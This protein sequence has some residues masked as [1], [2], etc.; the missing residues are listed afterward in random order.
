MLEDLQ[1]SVDEAGDQP[2]YRRLADAIAERIA[3]GQLAVGDR[4]PPQREIASALGINVTTVTRAFSTLQQR[5]LVEARPGRG[6][7]VVGP[8]GSAGGFKSAPSDESG[9]I[10]LSVNRPATSAYLDALA[11]LLPRLVKDRRYSALQD[12]HP[13]EGPL[14]ARAAI[15]EWLA[16][17]AGG[18]D[19]GRV[20]LTE[21]AQHGLACVLAAVAER[22][23]V[24]LADSV[25][26]QGINAL[27][28][29]RGLDL[30]GVAMDRGGMQPEAFDAACAQW[31]PRAVFLVPSLHNPATITL[32]E[33]RRRAL[34]AVAR[35]HNVIIIEDDV[36]RP[37]LDTPLPSFASIEPELTVYVSGFSKCVAP[38]LR[39]GFVIG[40]RAVMGH[41]A[42]ALRIDCWSVSPLTALIGTALLEEDLAGPLIERQKEELRQRQALLGQVLARF[43]VQTHETSTHAW[44]HLPEQWRG[45]AFARTCRQRGVGVL[46][47]DAFAIGRDP[48]PHAV[49][50]NVAAARS[51]EDLRRGLE[52]LAELMDYA[53]LHLPG[54]V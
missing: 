36:Y 18:G 19:P 43:D 41:V 22:G 51:R 16:P 50:I 26:Y 39:L 37:L 7:L 6:T 54:M 9:F 8:D 12:Y 14:W 15:A 30:R 21:G 32:S 53:H 24:V 11:G 48:V 4:L 45:A 29:S 52:I 1:L 35:R 31:R 10:D 38:G 23:D 46:P 40:P 5:G 27:C 13:S 49:R 17:V 20:V 47:G 42:A 33:G 34:V 25:T 44:L 2:I 3:R 28:H